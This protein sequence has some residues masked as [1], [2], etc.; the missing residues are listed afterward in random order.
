MNSMKYLEGQIPNEVNTEKNQNH[1]IILTD[2]FW[3][4][5]LFVLGKIIRAYASTFNALGPVPWHI[6]STI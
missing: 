2:V 5:V 1:K 6:L 3:S 4:S